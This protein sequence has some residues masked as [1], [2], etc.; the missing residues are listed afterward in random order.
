[1]TTEMTVIGSG[2]AALASGVSLALLV[3]AT[4]RHVAGIRFEHALRRN[5]DR[6]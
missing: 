1:M 5:G 2:I 4:R 6:H 3:E